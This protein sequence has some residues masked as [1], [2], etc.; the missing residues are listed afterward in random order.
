MTAS[1]QKLKIWETD[2]MIAR[3]LRWCRIRLRDSYGDIESKSIVRIAKG[4]NLFVE[5]VPVRYLLVPLLEN[6]NLRAAALC[7]NDILEEHNGKHEGTEE[8]REFA[9]QGGLKICLTCMGRS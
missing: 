5:F 9:T 8:S 2:D 1:Y 4:T 6:I 7:M 3:C